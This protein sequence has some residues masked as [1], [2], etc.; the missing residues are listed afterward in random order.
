MLWRS[1]EPRS[2]LSCFRPFFDF[3]VFYLRS[4]KCLYHV[5]CAFAL[6]S[7]RTPDQGLTPPLSAPMP[8]P[9]RPLGLMSPPLLPP[10]LRRIH[11]SGSDGIL[12]TGRHTVARVERCEIWASAGCNVRVDGGADASIT[13]CI[14]RDG[15][16]AGVKFFGDKTRGR[17]EGCSIY[18]HARDGVVLG[19]RADAVV[20]ANKIHGG[21]R[22]GVCVRDNGTRGIIE[23]NHIWANAFGGV[24]VWDKCTPVIRRNV[25]RDHAL[26][27][28]DFGAGCGVYLNSRAEGVV[29]G[30]DNVFERNATGDVVRL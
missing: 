5:E 6:P 8:S 3:R 15:L 2:R 22:A 24:K 30:D 23:G 17:V 20:R 28:E 1:A 4:W 26:G 21:Q 14:L 11:D 18:G 19:M 27:G 7:G 16:R 10:R 13:D 9:G 25:I 29:V 12:A